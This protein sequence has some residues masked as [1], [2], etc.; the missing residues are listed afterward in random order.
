MLP[1]TLPLVRTVA[2]SW[3]SIR[4]LRGILR[5][6]KVWIMRCTTIR[7]GTCR[8]ICAILHAGVERRILSRSI[9]HTGGRGMT[10]SLVC[11]RR[12]RFQES[13]P[14]HSTF[15]LRSIHSISRCRSHRDL[16][17]WSGLNFLIEK[18]TRAFQRAQMRS[19]NA[20]RTARGLPLSRCRPDK[21]GLVPL[22][23]GLRCGCT[24]QV[25]WLHKNILCGSLLCRC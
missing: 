19:R 10:L 6:C 15:A 2:L 23:L 25:L 14:R 16:P 8:V 18:F 4:I 3:R 13:V 21:T 11:I 5:L 7:R 12:S 9:A 1:H 17:G 22:R 20:C 24:V